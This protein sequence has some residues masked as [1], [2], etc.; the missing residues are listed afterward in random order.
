[1]KK[2]LIRSIEDWVFW[3]AHNGVD[4]SFWPQPL[5]FPCIGVFKSLR[6]WIMLPL[7]SE[8]VVEYVYE[9]DFKQ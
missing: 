3:M 8:V 4:A 7:S 2:D 6:P 5:Q 1:M 9:S